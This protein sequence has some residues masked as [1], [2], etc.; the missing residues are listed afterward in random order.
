MCETEFSLRMRLRSWQFY[1]HKNDWLLPWFLWKIR[2]MAL[3]NDVYGNSLF[4]CLSVPPPASFKAIKLLQSNVTGSNTPKD[5]PILQNCV[6]IGKMLPGR[7][8]RVHQ[9]MKEKAGDVSVPSEMLEP[10]WGWWL[11]QSHPI[12]WLWHWSDPWKNEVPSTWEQLGQS[13][14]VPAPRKEHGECLDTWMFLRAELWGKE[15]G[16]V[17]TRA[18]RD[19][20]KA[21]TN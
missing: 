9:K 13:R 16:T 4:T 11:Q 8:E 2:F 10:P 3:N 17:D 5:S 6:C 15:K 18:G 21:R 12:H 7:E 19:L 1:C 14:A 20:E